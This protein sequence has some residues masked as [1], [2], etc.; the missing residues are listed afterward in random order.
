MWVKNDKFNTAWYNDEISWIKKIISS[1]VDRQII[2][3][4]FSNFKAFHGDI[5]SFMFSVHKEFKVS[6]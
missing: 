3:R 2:R 1:L 4:V 5:L 6:L